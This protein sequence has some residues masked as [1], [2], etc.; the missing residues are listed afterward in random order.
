MPFDISSYLRNMLH[1]HPADFQSGTERPLLH[2]ALPRV[3]FTG[4]QAP[5]APESP[6][7]SVIEVLLEAGEDPN[8]S[9]L[10]RT[11]WQNALDQLH[12]VVRLS[13]GHSDQLGQ[14]WTRIFKLLLHYEAD[15]H[16]QIDIDVDITTVTYSALAVV[17]DLLSQC[18]ATGAEEL[19]Q[20]LVT[21]GAT[22]HRYIDGR[23]ELPAPLRVITNRTSGPKTAVRVPFRLRSIVPED[24]VRDDLYH[25]A[26]RSGSAYQ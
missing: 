26:L 11:P 12:S 6:S 2:V 18:D 13:R 25:A 7:F 16:A 10:G 14:V 23:Q 3:H 24:G 8:W 4:F 9:Y 22:Y 5:P 19:Q 17:S 20:L 15:V 21:K 1:W